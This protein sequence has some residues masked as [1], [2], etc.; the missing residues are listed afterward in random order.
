MSKV[1][2]NN[3]EATF[4]ITLRKRVDAYFKDNNLKLTGDFRLHLKTIV[5]FTTFLSGY[6]FLIFFT[7]S[8]T[9]LSLFICAL[10]GLNVASIGFNVMHDGAH[11]SYSSRK[12]INEVMGYSLNALGGS[13]YLWKLKH[14]VNHH[15]FTNVVGVDD[16]IDIRPFVRVHETQKK[17]A[18][19]RYQHLYVLFLYCLTYIFWIFFQDNKKYFTRKIAEHSP[20]KKM[21]IQEHFIFWG[22]KAIYF[23]TFLILPIMYVGFLPTL[24]GYGIMAIVAGFILSIVFQLAHILEESDFVATSKGEAD[25]ESNWA[26]HQINT[27]ANF[28][29]RNKILNWIV[30]GLNFQVEHHLFPRISHVHYPQ[31]NKIV[32]ATCAEYGVVYREYRSMAGA[33]RS[34]LIHLKRVGVA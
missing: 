34:H 11:G 10:M 32:Q 8:S 5:L 31:I 15:S 9:L 1:K 18:M 17:R 25:V 12:W 2:F 33:L 22:S 26:V 14:N 21:N 29:T 6:I 27:T 30:G 13:V 20:L 3:S 7:P 4:F 16:D 24:L 28:G 23:F 19:H